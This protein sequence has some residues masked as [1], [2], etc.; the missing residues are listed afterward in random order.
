M[1]RARADPARSIKN[2]VENNQ[3]VRNPL[4]VLLCIDVRGSQEMGFYFFQVLAPFRHR[5]SYSGEIKDKGCHT[6][7]SCFELYFSG[8]GGKDFACNAS[9]V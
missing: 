6:D 9:P 5:A 2:A 8:S 7:P 3:P 4:S 1:T